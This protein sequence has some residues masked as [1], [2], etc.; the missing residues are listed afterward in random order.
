MGH[1]SFWVV[2]LAVP[3]VV[4][5]GNGFLRHLHGVPQTTPADLMLAFIVFD[6]AV[7]IQHD[8]FQEYVK[9]DV[10]RTNII[11]IYVLLLIL[12]Y[13]MWHLSV[14]RLESALA[15]RY[16]VRQRRYLR[17]PGWLIFAGF[18][19]TVYAFASN[20]LVFAYGG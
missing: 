20:T 4:V 3:L 1:L 18:M 5:L 19:M 10:L 13:F 7:I 17:P 11:A 14:F 15:S 9:S 12:N 6:A 8:D 16:S 2:V